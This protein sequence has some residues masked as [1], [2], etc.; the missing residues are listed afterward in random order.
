MGQ[1]S[2]DYREPGPPAPWEHP[3]V[4]RLVRRVTTAFVLVM[5]VAAVIAIAVF[6]QMVRSTTAT[7]WSVSR[8][9][10]LAEGCRDYRQTYPDRG[11]PASLA[12]LAKETNGIGPFVDD[13]SLVDGWGRPFRYALVPNGD[14]E[15]EPYIWSEWT[16]SDGR[17]TLHGAK[18]TADGKVIPFGPPAD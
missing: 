18:L 5:A 11:Y 8:A 2:D 3:A 6:G 15:L 4:R 1:A 17:T 7:G 9:V 14:G 12:E 13:G 10:A 16:H